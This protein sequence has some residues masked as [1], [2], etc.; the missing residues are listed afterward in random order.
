M[1]PTKKEAEMKKFLSN[2]KGGNTSEAKYINK[3]PTYEKNTEQ[4]TTSD[5]EIV[6]PDIVTSKLTI[7][8]KNHKKGGFTTD[9]TN[10]LKKQMNATGKNGNLV[11]VDANGN[12]KKEKRMSRK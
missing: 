7:E 11:L 4:Y 8:V 10:Q 5:G 1:T 9:D 12:V 6:I 2:V 3:H